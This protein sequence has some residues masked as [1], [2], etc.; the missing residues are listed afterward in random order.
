MTGFVSGAGAAV[1]PEASGP[2]FRY[3]TFDP[4]GYQDHRPDEGHGVAS[5]SEAAFRAGD[6]A[7][8]HPTE[9]MAVCPQ[10]SGHAEPGHHGALQHI[11]GAGTGLPEI[12]A[13]LNT[14]TG[15]ILDRPLN[16]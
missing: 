16:C 11:A 7:Q 5:G 8:S 10:H 6:L 12:N 2:G 15:A 13:E 9:Q 3:H 1:C 14:G 4:V